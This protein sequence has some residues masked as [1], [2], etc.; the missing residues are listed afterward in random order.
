[1][2]RRGEAMGQVPEISKASVERLAA[3][4]EGTHT[5]PYPAE[6]DVERLVYVDHRSGRVTVS[7]RGA[8]LLDLVAAEGRR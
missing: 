2:S 8:W 3:I 5:G 4:A 7:V 1:M 6:L